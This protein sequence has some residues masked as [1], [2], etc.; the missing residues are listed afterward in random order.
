[1]ES[2]AARIRV[3]RQAK[4]FT[5]GDLAALCGVTRGVVAP[6]ELGRLRAVLKWWRC[7]VRTSTTLCTVMSV[8]SGH[9]A[10]APGRRGPGP[11][12]SRL[13]HTLLGYMRG[14]R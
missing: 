6:W 13:R 3:L 1:M 2:M 4:G 5:Q 7:S 9:V 8:E 11:G 10:K 12:S 14:R